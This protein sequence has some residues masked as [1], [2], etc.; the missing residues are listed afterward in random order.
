MTLDKFIL[1]Y[2]TAG[3]KDKFFAK[4]INKTYI[5]F[6][7]KLSDCD[8][9]VEQ[10]CYTERDGQ[11]VFRLNSAIKYFLFVMTVVKEYTDIEV[12]FEKDA[13]KA[14]DMLA[15]RGL[16]EKL[17]VGI[18][19]HEYK[20]FTTLLSMATDDIMEN[21]RSFAGYVDGKMDLLKLTLNNIDL[22]GIGNN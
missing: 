1:E 6:T 10:A 14:Y 13:A 11:K 18:G 22:E 19:E 17:M 4:H 12:D 20:E 16:I 2:D 9:I 7:D 15:E 3:D 21:E 8:K 5:S